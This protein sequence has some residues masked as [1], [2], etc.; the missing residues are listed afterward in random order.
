MG[1]AEVHVDAVAG[2]AALADE[3]RQAT[4]GDSDTH[5]GGVGDAPARLLVSARASGTDQAFGLGDA[6]DG[7]GLA[8]PA[9]ETK[10]PVGFRDHLPTLEIAH[11]AASL[12]P[13][14][15]VG[16]IERGGEGRELLG[17]EAR[18]LK[19]DG[20]RHGFRRGW[21]ERLAAIRGADQLQRRW[22]PLDG[23]RSCRAAG[24]AGPVGGR[25]CD[26]HGGGKQW[27]GEEAEWGPDAPPGPQ[28]RGGLWPLS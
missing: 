19:R 10:D 21:R 24:G 25:S 8:L 17:G 11:A 16:P 27:C 3:G 28:L 20:A 5:T 1:L 12:L 18:G 15:D 6:A 23:A 13:L 14:V 7:D 22:G 9:I 26:G 4:G 2:A